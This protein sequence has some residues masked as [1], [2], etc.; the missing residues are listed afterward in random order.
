MEKTFRITPNPVKYCKVAN[1][2]ID[3]DYIKKQFINNPRYTKFIISREYADKKDKF[4]LHYHGYFYSHYSKNTIRG[5]LK[6][7]CKKQYKGNEYLSISEKEDIN[8]FARNY[9]CKDDDVVIYKGFTKKQI[10]KH[11]EEGKKYK[12]KKKLYDMSWTKRVWY[13]LDNK[14]YKDNLTKIF[15]KVKIFNIEK[16]LLPIILLISKDLEINPPPPHI[17]QKIRMSVLRV[18]FPNAFREWYIS[19]IEDNLKYKGGKVLINHKN[20]KHPELELHHPWNQDSA[21]SDEEDL[22]E[23][24]VIFKKIKQ[25]NYHH[26][27]KSKYKKNID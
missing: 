7:M 5:H 11:I 17:Y 9:I 16:N 2:D 18:L 14:G 26:S 13:Y 1:N 10:K 21:E 24:N 8:D 20:F 4:T 19:Y 25:I 22:I 12:E 15:S 6:A 23:K 27:P 3:L